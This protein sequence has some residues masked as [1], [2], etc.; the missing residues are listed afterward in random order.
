MRAL[1][2]SLLCVGALAG[3]GC[4]G[5]AGVVAGRA[6]LHHVYRHVG[7]KGARRLSKGLCAF[8]GYRA[9][10]DLRHAHPGWSG[11]QLYRAARSCR[12]GFRR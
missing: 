12:A 6:V 8:H 1:V 11:Y 4:G 9:A 5:L 10:T 3:A 2:A 7:P